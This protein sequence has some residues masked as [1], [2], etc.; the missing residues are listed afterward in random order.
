MD[1]RQ[2][3][4]AG[5]LLSTAIAIA[6]PATAAAPD[7]KET[8]E[9]V[10]VVAPFGARLARSRV[11]GNVQVATAEEIER[12]QSL[13]LTDFLNR[14]F[15]SVS[16]NHAQNNPL[17]PDVTF[18]GFTASPLLGLPPGLSVYQNGVRINEPFGDTVNWDESIL[19][20]SSQ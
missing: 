3:Q 19:P 6:S 9:E 5:A 1:Q 7:P 13:D 11:P 10:I 17:Q 12:S 20:L 16:I 18:R 8:L 4:A 15:S 2:A 14:S